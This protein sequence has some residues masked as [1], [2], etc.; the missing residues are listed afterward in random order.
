MR[1]HECSNPWHIDTK[2][3][4]DHAASTNVDN[5]IHLTVP[6][7]WPSSQTKTI[8]FCSPFIVLTVS[9]VANQELPWSIG[10]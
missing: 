3:H 1:A 5:T 10:E 7:K 2:Y 4:F 9:E 8:G 6:L